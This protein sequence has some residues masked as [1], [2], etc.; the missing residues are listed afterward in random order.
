M[1]PPEEEAFK[2]EVKLEEEDKVAVFALSNSEVVQDEVQSWL[3]ACCK[4]GSMSLQS[5]EE[6]STVSVALGV[7]AKHPAPEAAALQGLFVGLQVQGPKRLL[8]V[9]SSLQLLSALVKPL[10]EAG[11]AWRTGLKEAQVLVRHRDLSGAAAALVNAGHSLAAPAVSSTFHKLPE[12]EPM[13][14]VGAWR[15]LRREEMVEGDYR[16]IEFKANEAPLRIVTK[17]GYFLEVGIAGFASR[18]G[19]YQA[20]SRPG[21]QEVVVYSQVSL[22]PST[23]GWE[24]FL[25][26]KDAGESMMEVAGLPP[27][28]YF[29]VWQSAEASEVTALELDDQQRAGFWLFCGK[30]FGRVAGPVQAGGDSKDGEAVEGEVDEEGRC[31][32]L[33]DGRFGGMVSKQL[34]SGEISLERGSKGEVLAVTVPILNRAREHWKVREWSGDPFRTEDRQKRSLRTTEASS[35]KR[36]RQDSA[37]PNEDRSSPPIPTRPAPVATPFAAAA[38][39][40]A[41]LTGAPSG[42]LGKHGKQISA[43]EA[44]S[45][46]NTGHQA[47]SGTELFDPFQPPCDEGSG[48]LGGKLF[49][50]AS[51][52]VSDYCRRFGVDGAA[53]QAL[54]SLPLEGQKAIMSDDLSGTNPS[55]LLMARIRKAK[56]TFR[57]TAVPP[58]M[59]ASLVQNV[60][61]PLS[62][63]ASLPFSAPLPGDMVGLFALQNGLDRTAEATLR[64]L[65]ADLQQRVLDLGPVQG[66]NPSAVLMGRIRLVRTNPSSLP[67]LAGAS[68][69]GSA[70]LAP[71]PKGPPPTA[72]G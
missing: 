65:P 17:T 50:A 8:E 57:S 53:E 18:A 11:V 46:P 9:K 28:N 13:L 55:A 52:A 47:A 56:E 20:L 42:S 12:G 25:I 32:A 31:T 10:S 58:P 48:P 61:L 70:R 62:S 44:A 35:T 60:T 45:G 3:E 51:D 27:K 54:R 16:M 22:E 69:L 39:A 71:P 1:A 59:A 43:R 38:A 5:E 15:L 36:L 37:C 66:T 14:M 68:W 33:R 26:L 24:R 21:G 63:L 64:A 29:E 34:C 41:A 72:F 49:T 30:C 6:Q 2:I 67:G 19:R 7:L 40:L 23:G 4:D